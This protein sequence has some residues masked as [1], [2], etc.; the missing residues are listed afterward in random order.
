MANEAREEQGKRRMRAAMVDRAVLALPGAKGMLALLAASSAVRAAATVGQA[1]AL[2]TALV[3]LWYGEP[4]AAQAGWIAD[5]FACF[6]ARQAVSWFEDA[7]L[8]RYACA[9]AC[10]L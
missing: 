1:F 3:N 7:R 8:E 4:V 10:D 6:A 9:R 5:F 2:A